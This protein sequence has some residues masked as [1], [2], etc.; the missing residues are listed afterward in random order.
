MRLTVE[1]NV[2]AMMRKSARPQV[3]VV[4]DNRTTA[5]SLALFL[6]DAGFTPITVGTGETALR[7]MKEKGIELVLLDLNLPDCDGLDVC[8]RI[9]RQRDVPVVMLTARSSEEDIVA[10][11]ELGA[12]DYIC[13]PFRSRELVA[14]V[15]RAL[16]DTGRRLDAILWQGDL[17]LDRQ[18]RVASLAG[19]PLSLTRSE[20]DLLEVLMS[21]PGRVLTRAQLIELALGDDFDGFDRTIDT[22]I[23]S[24]RKK[25][26]ETRTKPRYILSELGVGYRFTDA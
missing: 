18:R 1:R 9:R 23:W 12:Q 5:D 6:A 8:R 22:H 25:L 24:I 10:G 7:M 3:L 21:R 14:R 16:R 15:R 26:G 13:K 11:L 17:A 19:D 4:E 2:E 20:F